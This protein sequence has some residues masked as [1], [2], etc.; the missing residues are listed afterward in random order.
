M[1]LHDIILKAILFMGLTKIGNDFLAR[2]K[3]LAKHSDDQIEGH[4]CHN[5][6]SALPVEAA[7][8]MQNV[9][10]NSLETAQ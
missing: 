4:I 5:H 8:T 9:Y 1:L 6:G 7:N 10:Y 3:F 2:C